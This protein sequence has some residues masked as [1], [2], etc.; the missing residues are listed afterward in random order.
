MKSRKREEEMSVGDKWIDYSRE[1]KGA[2]SELSVL[3]MSVGGHTNF[4]KHA[5]ETSKD[6]SKGN[7]PTGNRE[8]YKSRPSRERAWDENWGWPRKGPAP[9]T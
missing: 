7:R 5:K 8:E 6:K 2:A 4:T 3:I 1:H 9:V